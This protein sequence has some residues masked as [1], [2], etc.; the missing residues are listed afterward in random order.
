MTQS[1]SDP[2]WRERVLDANRE[3]HGR[4]AGVYDETEPH[5]RPENQ[6]KVKNRLRAMRDRAGSAR[7]LDVGCGTGFILR[8]AADLFDQIDGVDITEEMMQRIPKLGD[9][10]KVQLAEAENLPFADN[11]F[12]VV[13]A[14]SVFDHLV[15]YRVTL[16]EIRRVLKPSGIFYADL[17]PNKEFWQ[18]LVG[19]APADEP[20]LDPI[21]ARELAMVR[22]NHKR[23][24]KEHGIASETFRNAEPG[25][26]GG[27]IDGSAVC[28][29]AKAIGYSGQQVLYDWFLGQGP[30][31]HNQS[32]ET[33][34]TIDDYLQRLGPVSRPLYKYLRFVLTK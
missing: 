2:P 34:E 25:K 11:T 4:L 27:G 10:V 16:A 12:D 22:E 7:M 1:R 18:T 29:D 28:A 26:L 8:L 15:D 3:V 31:M 21:V 17:I 32:F 24:E 6:A 9:H 14:Y 23:I 30:V 19:I 5:F 20:S 13:T 33:A